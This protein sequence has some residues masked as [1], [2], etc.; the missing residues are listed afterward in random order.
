MLT[1]F[2]MGA[3]SVSADFLWSMRW[4]SPKRS[5]PPGADGD[6][7][8]MRIQATVVLFLGWFFYR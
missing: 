1:M 8:N 3:L 5:A 7:S 6:T 4:D 2:F